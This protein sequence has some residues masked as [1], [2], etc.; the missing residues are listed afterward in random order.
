MK[1]G[2]A[3][4]RARVD[5]WRLVG[6]LLDGYELLDNCWTSCSSRL[7]AREHYV[8]FTRCWGS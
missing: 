7:G 5:D 1:V 2:E 3:G 8:A 4:R 6:D